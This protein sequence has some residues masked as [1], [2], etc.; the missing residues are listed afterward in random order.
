MGF[1]FYRSFVFLFLNLLVITLSHSFLKSVVAAG[2]R[3]LSWS[4]F[5]NNLSNVIDVY[6]LIAINWSP[7]Q[8][9]TLKDEV[10]CIRTKKS[11]SR[12]IISTFD[13]TNSCWYE[14]LPLLGC[15][16]HWLLFSYLTW[17][18]NLLPSSFK[19]MTSINLLP[20]QYC[21][22]ILLVLC[23]CALVLNRD[24]TQN[25]FLTVKCFEFSL[26]FSKMA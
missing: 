8:F 17:K 15:F 5:C 1:F 23:W 18:M 22:S 12:K 13:F 19:V 25:N 7:T 20:I 2:Y 9:I 10:L 16:H 3:T 6:R 11:F 4:L 26:I 24:V 14:N 21:K